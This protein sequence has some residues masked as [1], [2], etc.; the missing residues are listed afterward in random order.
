[1]KN[2]RKEEELLDVSKRL[3]FLLIFFLIFTGL[4][5]ATPKFNISSQCL[6]AH[7]LNYNLDF[8]SSRALLA[9]LLTSDEGGAYAQ[10]LNLWSYGL[11]ALITEEEEVFK[12]Y[13][14][15]KSDVL[16]HIKTV[17]P[18]VPYRGYF[19]ADI[20]FYSAMVYAKRNELYNAAR[21]L[22]KAHGIIA[23]NQSRFPEFLPN[24]K[25]IGL[26][27]A[28]LSTVPE[29]YQWATKMLGFKGDLS[30]GIK[31]LKALSHYSGEDSLTSLIA[32]ESAYM[33]SFALYQLS[34]YRRLAWKETLACT[35]DYKTSLMSNFFR[36]N[37]ALKMNYNQSAISA[38]KQRPRG[39]TYLE[40]Y[41]LDYLQGLA[42]LQKQD[43]S[44]SSYL[45][46]FYNRFKGNSFKKSC[47]QKLSWYYLLKGELSTAESF[48]DKILKVG[49]VLNEE[50]KAAEHYASKSLPNRYLLKAR[51]LYDGGYHKQ[52]L[53]VL[54]MVD[55]KKLGSS[56]LKA[57]F[58]YRKGKVLW[59]TGEIE[60]AVT[61]YMA[62]TLFSKSS[63]EYYGPYACIYLADYY[64][65]K[66]QN[67][68]A[69]KYY[70]MALSY[71]QNLEYTGS[72]ERRAKAGL[73]KL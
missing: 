65:G 50:D 19:L 62:C 43:V 48:K 49:H 35:R 16:D 27:E 15:L 2:L 6:K 38:L 18:L 11:E 24:N 7:A 45:H 14:S 61:Y 21:E 30:N 31:K 56:Q 13:N 37:M 29:S 28:Y 25:V 66:K 59:Q 70:K 57:E 42:L 46:R 54:N 26:M 3:S 55:Y 68:D 8:G 36:S 39:E 17:S 44:A 47:L 1:M 51:L 4:S 40:F 60:K 58:S 52:A 20:H 32:R 53:E 64:L 22:N 33:Y 71:K 67:E 23:D 9:Q 10:Y 12:Q 34:G 73:K 41:F 5:K 63:T 69:K 72:I